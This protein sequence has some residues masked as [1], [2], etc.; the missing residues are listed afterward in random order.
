MYTDFIKGPTIIVFNCQF[1]KLVIQL[2]KFIPQKTEIVFYY[3]K[4]IP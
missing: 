3:I 2:I 1:E 4:L